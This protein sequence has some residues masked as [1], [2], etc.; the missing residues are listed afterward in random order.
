M[1]ELILII[2]D[3]PDIASTLSYNLKKQGFSTLIADTG[4]AGLSL[5][6]GLQ[7]PDLILLDLMQGLRTHLR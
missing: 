7:T 4:S 2:E 1:P 3:E 5:A 6:Q